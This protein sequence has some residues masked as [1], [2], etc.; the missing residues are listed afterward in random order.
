MGAEA[1][2]DGVGGG[3]VPVDVRRQHVVL[4]GRLE[5]EDDRCGASRWV[6]RRAPIACSHASALASGVGPGRTGGGRPL[7][8]GDGVVAGQLRVDPGGVGAAGPGQRG[9]A[10]SSAGRCRPRG[11]RASSVPS[12]SPSSSSSA[13]SRA[14]GGRERPDEGQLVVAARLRVASSLRSPC[15]QVVLERRPVGR[16]REAVDRLGAVAGDPADTERVGLGADV[17]PA[18]GRRSRWRSSRRRGSCP[19]P[20]PSTG[21]GPASRRVG[22][23][24]RRR[25]PATARRGGSWRRSGRRR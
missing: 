23:G 20:R 13:W 4:A 8:T 11:P 7:L 22:P 3:E 9:A 16:G 24:R 6:R 17:A 12:S 1:L 21:P 19:T 25:W 10:A 5:G 2:P 14:R 18:P 15:S